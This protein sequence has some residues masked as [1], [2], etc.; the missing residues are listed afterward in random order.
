MREYLHQISEVSKAPDPGF[1]E[2]ESGI[3]FCKNMDEPAAKSG[4]D[5]FEENFWG[6]TKKDCDILQKRQYDYDVQKVLLEDWNI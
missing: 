2:R 3:F 6:N 5:Y 4:L 1:L